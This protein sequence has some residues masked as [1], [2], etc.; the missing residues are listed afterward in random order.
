MDPEELELISQMFDNDHDF[1]PQIYKTLRKMNLI[2]V[3]PI[4]RWMKKHFHA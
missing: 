4:K 1:S 2:K 3:V